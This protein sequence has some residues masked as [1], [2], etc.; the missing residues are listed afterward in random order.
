M[1]ST[2]HLEPFP[3]HLGVFDAHCHPTDTMASIDTIPSMRARVLTI[4]ATRAQDQQLIANV[5]DRLQ[6]VQDASKST[7][8]EALDETRIIP[9]FGW[10]P[11]FSHQLFDETAYQSRDALNQEEKIQ[12]YHSVL[13][14]KPEASANRDFL[15][16]LPEP[17]PLSNFLAQTR[18]YLQKYPLALVGEVGIDKSFR[19]PYQ[20]TQEHEDQR[21][22]TLTPGGRE[23]RRLS[24]YRV[25]LDHQK[26]ILKAQLQL[27][28]EMQRAVSVHGVQAH[29]VVFD[30][31]KE[32]WKGHEKRVMSKRDRKLQQAV[33]AMKAEES[34]DSADEGPKPYPPRV[35]LH[36]YSGPSDPIK[37]YLHSSIPAE[38]FFSFSTAIN[39]STAA[40][41]KAEEVIKALPADRIL[42]ESDLHTAGDRMDQHLEDIIRKVCEVKNWN[43]EEGVTQL[44]KNW[45]TFV[46]DVRGVSG[47]HS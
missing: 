3:W 9:C 17:R 14:P 25:A 7:S 31:L 19:I 47:S 4:M 37:Q 32:T 30:V 8:Q 5:A 12:H 15:L 27:A 11:W 43:L 41:P 21:D 10:H 23:G 34:E 36:S 28:G 46:Y 18:E 45:H 13:A 16:G 35:C 20:W 38:I 6:V 1:A 22:D 44:K 26:K 40:A 33:V 24:P 39:F 29:G 2:E 42:V